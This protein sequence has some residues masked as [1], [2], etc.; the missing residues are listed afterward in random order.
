VTDSLIRQAESNIARF[1]QEIVAREDQVFVD[2]FEP[3]LR[4]ETLGQ[5]RDEL[6]ANLP[7][8]QAD[9][10]NGLDEYFADKLNIDDLLTRREELFYQEQ[11]IS[12]LTYMV[13][14][15]VAELCAA[16]GKFFELLNGDPDDPGSAPA[17]P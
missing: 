16:T 5:S 1:N 12:R 3:L 10:D 4:I 6:V 8:Y 9:Y 15:N 2:T 7:R 13:C 11:E 14:I 17:I